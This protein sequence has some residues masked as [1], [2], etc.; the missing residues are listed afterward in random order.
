MS[1]LRILPL[2]LTAL[3]TAAGCDAWVTRPM[4]YNTVRVIARTRAGEAVPGVGLTLYTGQR[5]MAYATTAA[6]GEFM[7]T[8]VPSGT[9]GVYASLPDGYAAVEDLIT[10][11]SSKVIDNLVVANDT[12]S[13]VRFT[14]LKKGP[15]VVVARLAQT[16]GAPLAGVPVALYSPT[17]QLG[18]GQTDATGRV[19][20]SDVPFGV[21]GVRATRPLLYRD[22]RT[23]GDSLYAVRDNL[24][25]DLGARDS[26]AISLA[27]C[28]GTFRVVAK[29]DAGLPAS[30]VVVTFYTFAATLGV[31]TTGADGTATSPEAPCA[32]QFG[33]Q[34]ASAPGYTVQS[35]R[36]TSF[37]DG[38][39]VVNGGTVDVPF[40]LHR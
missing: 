26:V 6:D 25:V 22:Y 23:P 14:F 7:F 12:L 37:V 24:I 4:L 8:L 19:V 30:G 2:L 36:G 20:F 10:A 39:T 29:D 34:I 38:L 21:Y 1:R 11:P 13:P 17:R 32:V 15:G 3:A 9:Y 33:V 35:G 27:K 5:P 40:R 28:A 31:A 18:T 16:T